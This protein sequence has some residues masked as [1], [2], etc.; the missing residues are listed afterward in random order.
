VVRQQTLQEHPELAAILAEFG[1][2]ISDGEMQRLN[3]A[4]DGQHRDAGDVA[5][6]F[7]KGK[8][9]LP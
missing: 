2:K 4:L 1:G 8:G 6:E 3:Y 7:L 9:L 5:R